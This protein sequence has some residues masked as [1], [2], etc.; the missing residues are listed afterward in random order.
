MRAI[1]NATYLL[2]AL[3]VFGAD[4]AHA[5][6]SRAPYR[7]AHTRGRY[8]RKLAWNP[9]LRGSR[10]SLLRQNEEID[11]L[12]LA[13]ISNDE[14]LLDLEERQE[15]IRIHDTRALMV[16]PQLD[17]TRKYC[18]PWTLQFLTDV[19][20]AYYA[21]FKKPL[22]VTSAVRTVEQQSKLRRKNK[23]AA[24]IDGD[25]ASSHLAGLTIDIGKRGMSRKERKWFDNY[26]VDMQRAHVIEAAEE[27]RQACYHIMV[28]ERYM[29]WRDEH[30]LARK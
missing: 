17:E 10:D 19:S 4:Y 6:H 3:A 8:L 16:S 1:R 29:E 9:M 13:R 14:E 7:R 2:I 28:S 23:N 27:R 18:R 15:L 30:E 24:P 25:T 20:D 22:Q 26:L 11:R 21:Q 12:Q 5:L